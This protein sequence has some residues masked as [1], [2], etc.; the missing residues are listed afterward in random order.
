MPSISVN[1]ALL[2]GGVGI[3]TGIYWIVVQIRM[4]R[5]NRFTPHLHAGTDLAI[6]SRLFSVVVPAHNEER[7]IERLVGGILGQKG[8]DFELIVVLD[9]CTDRTLERIRAVAGDDSRLR[10]VEVEECPEDWAGKCHAATKGAEIATGEWI[11]FTDADVGFDPAVLRASAGLMEDLDVDLLSAWT[12]LSASHWWEFVV[13]PAAAI[14]LLRIFPPDRVNNDERPR[15]FA[16]GQFLVFRTSTYRE[17]G[18]H[19][20]VKG[21]LLEDLAFAELLHQR[22]GRVRVVDAGDMVKT[23]MYDS[24]GGLLLG[25]RRILTE[26]SK[27]NIP[28]IARNIVLVL[29]SGLAPLLSAAAVVVG[30]FVAAGSHSSPFWWWVMG[31]GCFGLLSQGIALVRIFRH[32]R[33][34]VLGVLGWPLGCLLVAM[35]L[36]AAIRDLLTGRPV[37]WG[38]REYVLRPGPR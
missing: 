34:P 30:A 26:A 3:V 35:T 21:R 13:Q 15:S 9:R 36:A 19:A 11:L 16:N 18:G 27:R 5:I 1:L 23:N 2:L 32:G 4:I 38:G 22:K 37:R 24:I 12:S 17:F 20:A 33:M 6:P 25:W 31:S 29:G 10:V 14:T 7:V 28:F 8:V